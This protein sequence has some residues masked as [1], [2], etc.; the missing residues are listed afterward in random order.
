[1]MTSLTPEKRSALVEWL[2]ERY[3]DG[4]T[5]RDLERFFVDIQLDY[6]GSY[7]D[8]ELIGEI[9]DNTTEEEYAQ[10]FEE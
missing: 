8:E 1:M 10:L 4:M 2:V 9:E 6:I 7:T 5:T 3:L